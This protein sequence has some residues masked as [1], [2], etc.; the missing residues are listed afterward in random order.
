MIKKR[1]RV[2]IENIGQYTKQ[3]SNFN[4][5]DIN[6]ESR[7]LL[8]KASDL[9][10]KKA[11][12]KLK[13]VQSKNGNDSNHKAQQYLDGILRIPFGIYQ[14]EHI[15]SFLQ[16]FRERLCIYYEQYCSSTNESS[17]H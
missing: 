7:I 12:E 4:E 5:N 14:R 13:E 3:L 10:K 6:Y 11:M 9:V 2:V 17:S 1:F 8:M 15:F 16:H